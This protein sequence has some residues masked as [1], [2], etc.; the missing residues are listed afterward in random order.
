MKE[1]SDKSCRENQNTRFIFNNF[2]PKFFF[3]VFYS[4]VL[5]KIYLYSTVKHNYY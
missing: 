5:D 3:N 4:V 2:F 1:V